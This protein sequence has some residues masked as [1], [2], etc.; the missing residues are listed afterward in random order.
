MRKSISWPSHSPLQTLEKT[1]KFTSWCS[2]DI[3]QQKYLKKSARAQF[4]D[5]RLESKLVQSYQKTNKQV[6]WPSETSDTDQ[7]FEKI[8]LSKQTDPSGWNDWGRKAK[9][10]NKAY[11]KWQEPIQSTSNWIGL[12][13]FYMKKI[14]SWLTWLK[15]ISYHSYHNLRPYGF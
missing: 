9:N 13:F 3:R 7:K 8:F 1:I 10:M 5:A 4:T 11:K 14:S 6:S 12:F 2:T 15:P